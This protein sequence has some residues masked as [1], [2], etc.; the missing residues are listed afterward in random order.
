[1]TDVKKEKE[2]FLGGIAKLKDMEEK[3][4]QAALN[5]INA[6]LER[7]YVY[8]SRDFWDD[9]AFRKDWVDEL[10]KEGE[11]YP[12]SED[13]HIKTIESI[14]LSLSKKH[15]RI[16]SQDKM[17]I[18]TSQKALNLYLKYL[19]CLKQIPYTPHCP[20]DAKILQG[21]LKLGSEAKWTECDSTETYQEWIDAC[22]DSAKEHPC[23]QQALQN[24]KIKGEEFLSYWELIVWP[25]H[26]P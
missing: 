23:V 5:S 14:A 25:K 11:R 15:G 17:R 13:V 16:L 1:M 24:D 26:C 10:L 8:K 9:E 12:V 6:A 20:L 22:V 4:A 19:W 2:D 7:G 18:G 3:K 21:E